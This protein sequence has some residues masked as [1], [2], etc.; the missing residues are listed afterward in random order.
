[1]KRFVVFKCDLDPFW[2]PPRKAKEPCGCLTIMKSGLTNGNRSHRWM[3][4]CCNCG[5]KKSLNRGKIHDFDTKEDAE[6]FVRDNND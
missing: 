6:K 4:K 2:K 5:R 3:G 1:M